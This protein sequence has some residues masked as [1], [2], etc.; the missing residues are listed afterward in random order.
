MN[1]KD[2]LEITQVGIAIIF[3]GIISIIGIALLCLAAASPFLLA[4][5]M[6]IQAFN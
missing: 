6:I 2:F 3:A 4:L 5:W 1:F